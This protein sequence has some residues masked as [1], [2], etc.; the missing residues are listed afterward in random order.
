MDPR[1]D[2]VFF[3][4]AFAEGFYRGN[5]AA[6]VLLD[7]YPADAAMLALASEFGFSETAYLVPRGGSCYH[8]RWFTPEVEVP[9]CGHAT[10]ASAAA[11]F[12]GIEAAAG[13]LL[14]TSLSGE[15]RA[16][17]SGDLIEL[18]FPADNPLPAQDDPEI[19]DAL[20]A[21]APVSLWS[22][23]GTRNLMLVYDSPDKVLE[24]KPDFGGMKAISG[25]PWFGIA[26]TAPGLDTDYLCRYFAPCE[27]INEDPVTGSA[28]TFL[29][30]WWAQRLGKSTLSG[31]QA[32]ARGGRFQVGISGNRVLIRGGALIWLRGEIPVG[33]R[34]AGL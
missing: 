24:M 21:H 7:E 26:V 23:R 20:S 2:Q 29:A 27:G 4:N 18:D 25:K 31:Y 19:C 6:V 12:S 32:S 17:R 14:F 11:L 34:G 28:Q 33:W 13:R 5:T 9:L 15:L 8:I 22:A 10:L 3:V 16:A 30:P 1:L